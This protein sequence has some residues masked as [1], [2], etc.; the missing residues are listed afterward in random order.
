[1]KHGVPILPVVLHGPTE[2]W[3]RGQLAPFGGTVTID[4]LPE[5]VVTDKSPKAIRMTADQLRES[6]SQA[7]IKPTSEENR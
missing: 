4:V 2:I 5:V 7:L 3:P 6:Y 1:M